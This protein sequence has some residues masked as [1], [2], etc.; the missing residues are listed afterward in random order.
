M[1]AA[2]QA[3]GAGARDDLRYVLLHQLKCLPISA[4]GQGIAAV[5]VCGITIGVPVSRANAVDQFNRDPISF[6]G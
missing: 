1:R 5:P 4:R 6:D 2:D 3:A